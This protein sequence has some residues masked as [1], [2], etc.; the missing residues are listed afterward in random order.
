MRREEGL[1]SEMLKALRPSAVE[2]VRCQFH[3]D[4]Q[5]EQRLVLIIWTLLGKPGPRVQRHGGGAHLQG[6]RDGGGHRPRHDG[7]YKVGL[8][9]KDEFLEGFAS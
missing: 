7:L 4:Q 9:K 3:G 5:E 1:G 8:A 6:S 2:L